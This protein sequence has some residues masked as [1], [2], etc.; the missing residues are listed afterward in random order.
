MWS[1]GHLGIYFRNNDKTQIY[2]S[3][4]NFEPMFIFFLPIWLQNKYNGNL[5]FIKTSILDAD[6]LVVMPKNR[7]FHILSLFTG[8]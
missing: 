6:K 3:L 1:L 4:L 5:D 2:Y 7:Y 8:L